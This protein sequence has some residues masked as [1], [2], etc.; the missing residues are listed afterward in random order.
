MTKI[1]V[2]FRIL[3]ALQE[4]LEI[5][6]IQH[7]MTGFYN[8]KDQCSLGGTKWDFKYGGLGSVVTKV[9][10]SQNNSIGDT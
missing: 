4:N 7:S 9:Y 2:A 1:S 10:V 3:R 8:R 5:Y 6:P